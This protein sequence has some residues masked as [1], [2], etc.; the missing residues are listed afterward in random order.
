MRTAKRNF[1][2]FIISVT[3]LLG[4][5]CSAFTVPVNAA[6]PA[7]SIGRYSYAQFKAAKKIPV[8]FNEKLTVRGT[9]NPVKKYNAYID[10][11]DLCKLEKISSF[12]SII[13]YPTSSGERR[14]YV[15]TSDIFPLSSSPIEGG[16]SHS[17]ADV[18]VY[19]SETSF[20]AFGEIWFNDLVYSYGSRNDRTMVL[21][22]ANSGNRK[23]KIGWISNSSFK[24]IKGSSSDTSVSE[25]NSLQGSYTKGVIIVNR[26]YNVSVKDKAAQNKPHYINYS[27]SRGGDSYNKVIDQFSVTTNGRYKRTRNSTYCNIFAWD[28]MSAMNVSLP[29]WISRAG[30]PANPYE[31]GA[32]ELTANATYD[33][34]YKYGPKYG[35]SR[36][37]AQKAQERAN[38]GYP[39]VGVWKNTGK[40]SGHIAVIRPET[41][42]Y[43]YTENNPVVAQAGGTNY[44]I[45]KA[46]KG[47]GTS[48]LSSIV[49]WTHN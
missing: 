30:A 21:Y 26:S 47:F 32:S 28:V 41:K 13:V 17:K 22:E 9:I 7:P 12:Y 20:T 44:K 3:L 48:R 1:V 49:Y 42:S 10:K 8:F 19:P 23:Y 27:G 37:T 16:H 5:A 46:S 24:K 14:G 6:T 15:R 43:T 2:T 36:I 31:K 11:N 18:T 35:W 38:N 4:I 34:L 45:T 33:W 25:P 39:T 40:G 29:H